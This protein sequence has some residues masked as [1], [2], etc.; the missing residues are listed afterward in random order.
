MFKN[1]WKDEDK[2]KKINSNKLQIPYSRLRS[3]RIK[4]RDDFYSYFH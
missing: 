2:K 1:L 3:N 4:A